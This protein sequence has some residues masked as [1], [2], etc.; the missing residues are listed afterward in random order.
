MSVT[1]GKE[2]DNTCNLT[3]ASQLKIVLESEAHSILGSSYMD[4]TT[5]RLLRLTNSYMARHRSDIVE[6]AKAS[7]FDKD[8]AA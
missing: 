1:E 6:I 3:S 7:R 4:K 2:L 5:E 8:G